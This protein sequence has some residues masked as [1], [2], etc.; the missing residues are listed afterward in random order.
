MDY[1]GSFIKKRRKK[2]QV[3]IFLYDRK[4]TKLQLSIVCDLW[5]A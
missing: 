5:Q 4:W 2:L 1:P 3:L